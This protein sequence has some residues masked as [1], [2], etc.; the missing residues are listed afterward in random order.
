MTAR[1]SSMSDAAYQAYMDG[2]LEDYARDRMK[3][4]LATYEESLTRARDQRAS[5]LP[6]GRKTAGHHFFEVK[7]GKGKDSEVVGHVWLFVEG[8]RAWLYHVVI[9][10]THRRRGFGRQ[11]VELAATRAQELGAQ[12]LGLNV[13]ADN[14]GAQALYRSLGFQTTSMHMIKAL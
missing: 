13:F 12:A 10:S 4:D 3:S 5:L 1:L 6:Q 11:A 7:N 9:A 14:P 2:H 8:A